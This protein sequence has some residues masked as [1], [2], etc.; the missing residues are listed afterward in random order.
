MPRIYDNIEK[1][2]LPALKQALTVA[3]RADFCIGYFNLRGW[4]QIDSIIDSWPGGDLGCCRVLVGMQPAP[5]ESMQTLLSLQPESL[6]DQQTVLR[7]KK[8]IALEFRKQLMVGAPTNHDEHGLQ[9]LSQQ[10]KTGKVVVKLFLRHPLHAKLYL[11]HRHDHHNP[12][13]GYLGSSNLTFAG[14]LKQGELNVDVLEED[15]CLKLSHWFDDRWQDRWCLDISAELATIIDESWAREQ[16][17]APYH[18]YLKMVYHLSQEARAGLA[19][20]SIPDDLQHH[21]FDF[22]AAA[23]KIAARHLKHRNGVIIGDVVGLGKTMMATALARMFED[24]FGYSTLIICPKNLESM[25]EFYRDTY[26]LRAKILPISRVTKAEMDDIP[27]RYRLIVIDESHN[28]RNREGKRYKAIHDYIQQSDAKC[29]LLSATPYNKT[30]LDLSAQLRLFVPEDQVLGIRPEQLLRELGELEFVRRHQCSPS[31][32]AAFEKSEYPDDWRDLMRRYLV[33]RT[34]S[35]IKTHYAETDEH[36]QRFLRFADG[37]RSYFPDRMP[38]TVRFVV[39]EQNPFDTYAR[40]T[41]PEVVERINTLALPRYQLGNYVKKKGIPTPTSQEQMLLDGLARARTRLVGFCRTNLFKRLESGGPAFLQSIARHI[42]RNVVML[43]A[44]QSDDGLIP[45]GSPTVDLLRLVETD[46]DTDLL[47]AESD[48]DEPTSYDHLEAITAWTEQQFEQQAARIYQTYRTQYAPRFKWIRAGFFNPQLKTALLQDVRSLLAV[49]TFC[50]QWNAQHDAKL[51]A[52]ATIIQHE[53]PNE[54][55][56]IFSQFA[57]T[58][59]YVVD[60]LRARGI[61][62]IAAVQGGMANPTALVQRFSP[63]SNGKQIDLAD[64]IR[65]LVATD[66]LSE[67]QN[68]QDAHIVVNY[69][70]PW[71]IIRL[72]Q[73]AG[74]VDRIGQQARQIRCYSFVP[75]DGVE[76]ILRLRSRVRQRLQEN[77]EVIGTDEAFFEDDQNDAALVDLYHENAAVLDG[78]DDGEID[79]TSYAYQIWKNAVDAEP[80]LAQLIPN[81]PDVVYSS[82]QFAV[83]PH[84][85]A[86]VLIYLRSAD[87]NDALAWL[88]HTGKSVTQS[89]LAILQAAACHPQTDALPRHELHH[90]LVQQGITML[91]NEERALGGGLGRPSSARFR[92]YE[93][94]RTYSDRLRGTLFF[95]EE[96]ERTLDEIYRFPLRQSAVDTINR[97]LRAKIADPQL[98]ELVLALRAED[99]LCIIDD[100]EQAQEPR[101]ICSLGLYDGATA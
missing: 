63:R 56:L 85:P 65:V 24:S 76:R 82:R 46:A 19:E 1:P 30:Y 15:A 81:L 25:W 99:R 35:F 27:A 3:Y 6:I 38:T 50:G 62:Q 10:L 74:R 36:H 34:R 73:R 47:G 48:D 90:A 31:S 12:M 4:Q 17:L 100:Q 53:H 71:A 66:V 41:H 93:R 96:L 69:D 79:L 33:R 89:Q 87:G 28:L 23:V 75:H 58:V 78:D 14:L 26:G 13:I 16:S 44:L 83:R 64:Q 60:Q 39:D 88:D 51:N 97:Q 55:I 45:M 80:R 92:T 18:I 43:Q 77:A 95:S 2:L 98:A 59:T 40:M 20:F 84:A 52:L 70:L 72:I 57:D 11:V 5:S 22:Q 21:L 37:Q 7:L 67:G 42:L 29:I 61:T 49:L 32:L 9:R 68:L 54:K 101:L 91:V 86:G 8:Q 94:L